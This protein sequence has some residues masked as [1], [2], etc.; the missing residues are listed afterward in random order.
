MDF[1]KYKDK[2][3]FY[4]LTFYWHCVML[5]T[6]HL[7]VNSLH[8]Q[9]ALSWVSNYKLLCYIITVLCTFKPL[10]DFVSVPVV[11]FVEENHELVVELVEVVE[12]RTVDLLD[13]SGDG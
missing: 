9:D 11:V 4:S 7:F 12:Q 13:L 2:L 3:N 8:P 6:N 1:D 10:D 5:S